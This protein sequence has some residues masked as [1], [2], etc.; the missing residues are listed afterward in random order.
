MRTIAFVAIVLL[1]ACSC[2]TTQTAPR[3]KVSSLIT[4]QK[5]A[6]FG[7]CPVYT[8]E[9][10]TDGNITFNGKKNIDKIGTYK[11]TISQAEVE[12]LISAF[13]NADFFNLNKEYTAKKT[14]LPTT[15]ISFAYQGRMHWVKDYADA[16]QVLKNL[17][18]MI[19]DIVKADGWEKTK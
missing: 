11:K 13:L 7:Q 5:T 4:F 3:E 6:C 15:L 10:F 14:D 17:E 16:P 18:K 19:E 2:K 1:S 9:I 8:L 12:G